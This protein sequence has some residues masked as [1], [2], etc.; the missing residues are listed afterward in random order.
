MSLETRRF[1]NVYST[2]NEREERREREREEEKTVKKR[3]KIFIRYNVTVLSGV[4]I[5]VTDCFDFMFN[6]NNF[7]FLH[8]K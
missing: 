6:F 7:C 5:E 8:M 2:F 3:K 1:K 4:L